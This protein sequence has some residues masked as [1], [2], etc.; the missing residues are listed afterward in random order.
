MSPQRAAQ[1]EAAPAADVAEVPGLLDGIIAESRIARS[2]TERDRARDLIGEVVDG[3]LEGTI[4]VSRDLVSAIEAR[5]AELDER[6][7]EQLSAV[8]HAPEFQKLEAS[9]RGLHYLLHQT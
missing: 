4:T 3:V 1:P 9:W 2:E 6:M 7:S 8:M 5:I